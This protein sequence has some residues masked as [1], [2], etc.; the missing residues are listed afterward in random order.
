[1]RKT[2]LASCFITSWERPTGR[3]RNSAEDC[4]A[5]V[6][7]NSP[8]CPTKGVYP[9]PSGTFRKGCRKWLFW[10]WIVRGSLH[11]PT[12]QGRMFWLYRWYSLLCT[13]G[14]VFTAGYHLIPNSLYAAGFH[15]HACGLPF[16]EGKGKKTCFTLIFLIIV[17]YRLIY[18]R[19][20][21][22][23]FDSQFLR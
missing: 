3:E 7:M 10:K 22:S 13:G 18:V 17:W 15:K 1:M 20:I 12:L 4:F 9:Y 19:C 8:S 14:Q 11:L 6:W 2:A 23:H 21:A 16:S 5:P